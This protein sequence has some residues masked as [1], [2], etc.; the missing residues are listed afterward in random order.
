M[1]K[2]M[3]IR[4][5]KLLVKDVMLKNDQFPVVNSKELLKETLDIMNHFRLGIACI[6]NDEKKLEGVLTDGD[7][8]RTLLNTQKPLS[9]LFVD[10]AID[11]AATEFKYVEIS[12]TLIEAVILMGKFKIWDL[13][14]IDHNGKLIGLLHLHPV[15]QSLLNL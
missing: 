11:H 12:S 15:I 13:P 2:T 14:V 1:V 4:E 8:R 10:D 6:V 7:L 9:A 3:S 5:N